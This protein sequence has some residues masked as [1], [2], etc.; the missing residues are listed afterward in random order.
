MWLAASSP[1]A[2]RKAAADG[3]SILMDPHGSHS[4]IATKRRLYDGALRE[5]GHDPAGRVIPIARLGA[6]ASTEREAGE[7]ARQGAQWTVGSYA[8]APGTARNPIDRYV[9]D[10][11]IWGTPE[12]VTDQL[13]AL[14]QTLP[15][16]YLL[17]APL[18][19]ESFLLLTERVLPRLV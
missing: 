3:H 10:V 4:E 5:A 2:V 18:S 16:D 6:I 12:R 15:L 17:A 7:V 13:L 9:D 1:D 8:R 19:H 14:K 11:I